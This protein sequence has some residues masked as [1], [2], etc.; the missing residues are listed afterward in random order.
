MRVVLLEEARRDSCALRL[1][2]KRAT[3]IVVALSDEEAAAAGRDTELAILSRDLIDERVN[4]RIRG[5]S[6]GAIQSAQL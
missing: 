6:V 1:A 2:N 3:G 4:G 5:V